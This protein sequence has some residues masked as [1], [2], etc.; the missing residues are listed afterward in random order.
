MLLSARAFIRTA[1]KRGQYNLILPVCEPGHDKGGEIR[2]AQ[3]Q[4]CKNPATRSS[5]PTSVTFLMF[6][7]PLGASFP[8]DTSGVAPLNS[9][10]DV[11]YKIPQDDRIFR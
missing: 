5:P 6:S 3:Q 1:F 4:I 10:T 7:S 8:A 11:S 2:G 9:N